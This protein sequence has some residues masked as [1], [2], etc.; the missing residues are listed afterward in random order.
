MWQ[1]LW[2]LNIPGVVKTFLWRVCN[3]V[4]LI[5]DNLFKRGVTQDL[6]CPICG[7]YSETVV[8]ALWSCESAVAVWMESK[9]NIQKLSLTASSGFGFFESLM[10]LLDDE[11]LVLVT[12]LARRI[13]MRRNSFIFDGAFLP[14]AQLVQQGLASLEEY[15][16]A[17]ASSK[18]SR[19]GSN[20]PRM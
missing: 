4:L 18:S 12:S 17:C 7:L 20:H 16:A 13:W 8:H 5:R 15:R 11:D 19:E 1:K 2:A 14:P 6:L 10:N 9:K 3:N